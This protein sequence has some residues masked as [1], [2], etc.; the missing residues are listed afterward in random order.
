MGFSGAINCVS[1]AGAL[2]L[3]SSASFWID[4]MGV[5]PHSCAAFVFIHGAAVPAPLRE[6]SFLFFYCQQLVLYNV[7]HLEFSFHQDAQ[8]CSSSIHDVM[9]RSLSS[10]R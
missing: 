7:K 5:A 2:Q 3:A 1:A 10:Q 8:P 4:L 6:M 9:L